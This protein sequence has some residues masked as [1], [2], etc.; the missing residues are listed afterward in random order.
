MEFTRIQHR[1]TNEVIQYRIDGQRVTR[2]QYME[3]E[4]RQ[5]QY[6]KLQYQ[7]MSSSTT[8]TAVGNWRHTYYS[9]F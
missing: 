2:G 5:R 8:R 1:E 4:Q 9:N 6:G 3:E 7:Y